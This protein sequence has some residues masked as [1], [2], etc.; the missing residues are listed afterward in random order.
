MSLIYCEVCRKNFPKSK[1]FEHK[2]TINNDIL[3]HYFPQDIT[4]IIQIYKYQLEI[5]D[6]YKKF[7]KFL[8]FFDTI[9]NYET[10]SISYNCYKVDHY[11]DDIIYIMKNHYKDLDFQYVVRHMISGRKLRNLK[12]NRK[13]FKLK[14]EYNVFN[15][16]FYVRYL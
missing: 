16:K 4:N 1:F 15:K 12:I 2:D 6:K 10:L 7:S 3:N 9:R 13:I 14:I 8:D 11:I 5:Y